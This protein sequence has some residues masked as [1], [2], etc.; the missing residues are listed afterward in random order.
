MRKKQDIGVSAG[1]RGEIR[2]EMT[3]LAKVVEQVIAGLRQLKE[4]LAESRDR[5][6]KAT[7]KLDRIAEQTEAAATLVLDRVE[8][9]TQR[10][11][12]ILLAVD[13]IHEATENR[14]VGTVLDLIDQ[15]RALAT[16]N[17]D[18][19]YTIMDTLQFQD[20]TAQQMNHAA[21]LLEEV[22]ERLRTISATVSGPNAQAEPVSS[23]SGSGRPRVFDPHADFA[24]RRQE[25]KEID[26]LFAGSD[27]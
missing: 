20:I 9:I 6:P 7:S 27:E 12:Q 3:S 23:E 18:D 8:A 4:P 13:R 21:A 2:D 15:V 19:A 1:L 11:D 5:V 25:Q 14:D 16:G 26:N 10:E 22:E 17:R 24:D